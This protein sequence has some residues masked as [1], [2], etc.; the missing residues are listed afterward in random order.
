MEAGPSHTLERFPNVSARA[1]RIYDLF[2]PKARHSVPNSLPSDIAINKPASQLRYHGSLTDFPEER[3]KE[4][5]GPHPNIK[6]RF[7][8]LLNNLKPMEAE[9]KEEIVQFKERSLRDLDDNVESTGFIHNKNPT[10]TLIF[11]HN[12]I[13]QGQVECQVVRSASAWSIGCSPQSTEF[14]VQIAYLELIATSKHYIYIEN[15]FFISSCADEK[16]IKNQIANTLVQRI[17]QAHE[18]KEEFR[19]YV[20][21]PLL[22]GFAGEVY[23][24]NA[25]IMKLNLHW[26]YQTIC[27]S[28]NSMLKQLDRAIGEGNWRNYIQFLSLRTHGRISEEA[29]PCTEII[30]LHSKLMIVDDETVIVGSANINDRSMKGK[31]DSEICVVSNDKRGVVAW[32]N[33][34]QVEVRKTAYELRAKLWKEHFGIR[35]A[36]QLD[37][38]SSE[39]WEMI[40]RIAQV[41]HGL[42]RP[43]LTSTERCSDAI[44]TTTSATIVRSLRLRSVASPRNTYS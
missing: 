32:R 2:M 5:Q 34:K 43:T 29:A 21:L 17:L 6:Q 10:Q 9:D 8:K 28:R 37:P 27:R 11:R 19:I 42:F 1:N 39:T 33:G 15:Q 41:Q 20:L 44:R 35:D 22:P 13:T 26:E 24:S 23:D 40:R 3:E 18:K 36:Q 7:L 31:R 12:S 25:T 30:Y 16:N 38:V 4:N 14:S